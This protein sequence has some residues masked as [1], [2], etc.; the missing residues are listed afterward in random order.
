MSPVAICNRA[1]EH[2]DSVRRRTGGLT[3]SLDPQSVPNTEMRNDVEAL[4]QMEIGDNYF[5][6]KWGE[7][8][9]IIYD[10]TGEAL[11]L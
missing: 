11:T 10:R 5:E 9:L 6:K 4:C 1:G 7:P 2:H 8:K 3:Y